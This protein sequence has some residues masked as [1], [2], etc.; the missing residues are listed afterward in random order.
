M[1]LLHIIVAGREQ[2]IALAFDKFSDAAREAERIFAGAGAAGVADDYGMRPYIPA[3]SIQ[4]AF[5][6]DLTRQLQMQVELSLANARAQMEAQ[7]KVNADPRMRLAM[8]GQSA[9]AAGPNGLPFKI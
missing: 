8:A 2:P 7:Q 5:I 4:G 9:F 3:A 6:V 1:Y